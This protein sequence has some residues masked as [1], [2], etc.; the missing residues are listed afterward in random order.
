MLHEKLQVRI[1][2]SQ[3]PTNL[4]SINTGLQCGVEVLNSLNNISFFAGRLCNDRDPLLSI[5]CG[6]SAVYFA[7][8]TNTCRIITTAM[9]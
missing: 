3:Q 9:K 6:H 8:G 5:L 4:W 1:L 2:H 7:A